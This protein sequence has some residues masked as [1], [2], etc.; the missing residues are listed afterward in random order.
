MVGRDSILIS[1]SE[2]PATAHKSSHRPGEPLHHLDL[3]RQP[4]N[5]SWVPRNSFQRY[6]SSL[7][8][9]GRREARLMDLVRRHRAALSRW[10][11]IRHGELLAAGLSAR[12]GKARQPRQ[13]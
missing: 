13:G 10:A 8:Q 1:T 2:E 12:Q 7:S 3:S 6:V 4:R 9:K 11:T 5:K